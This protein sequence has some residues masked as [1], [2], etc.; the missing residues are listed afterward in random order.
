V[1]VD[2]FALD[3]FLQGSAKGIIA[4]HADVKRRIRIRE[5]IGRPFDELR[6]VEEESGLELIFLGFLRSRQI[7]SGEN[8]NEK[9][10]KQ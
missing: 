2:R 8:K 9:E 5:R 3:C 10:Q 4:E 7:S 1:T 6:E